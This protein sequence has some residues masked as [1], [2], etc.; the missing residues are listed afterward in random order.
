MAITKPFGEL[1]APSAPIRRWR[2]LGRLHVCNLALASSRRHDDAASPLRLR[3]F[4]LCLMQISRNLRFNVFPIR[5]ALR[6]MGLRKARRPAR[7][8]RR[9][10]RG[11]PV[12]KT[13][14][15]ALDLFSLHRSP[16]LSPT[17]TLTRASRPRR[18]GPPP[19]SPVSAPSSS[20]ASAIVK[21]RIID[22]SHA[23]GCDKF[24]AFVDAPSGAR[25]GAKQTA[26]RRN[27]KTD[28]QMRQ[29]AARAGVFIA[30]PQRSAR[31]QRVGFG[32]SHRRR[33]PSLSICDRRAPQCWLGI[34]RFYRS[35]RS[36][37]ISGANDDCALSQTAKLPRSRRYYDRVGRRASLCIKRR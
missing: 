36:I 25:P 17:E 18:S 21:S 31:V 12:D 34:F 23:I 33:N 37:H 29:G 28:L 10:R 7:R 4:R 22:R 32:F 6:M 26:R 9:R 24:E 13:A 11:V 2:R 30:R 1:I 5:G 19:Q 8:Q 15:I 16:P 3:H 14:H 20:A 27:I 35:S